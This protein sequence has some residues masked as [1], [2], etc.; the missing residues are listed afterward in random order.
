VKVVAENGHICAAGSAKLYDQKN[1]RHTSAILESTIMRITYGPV[2]ENGMWRL[3]T[4][5][6]LINLYR[7]PHIILEIRKGLLRLVRTCGKNP[8]RKNCEE[9]IEEYPRRKKVCCKVTKEMVG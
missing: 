6:E 2:K 5:H 9:G 8:R 7:E 3:C 1:D 4:N